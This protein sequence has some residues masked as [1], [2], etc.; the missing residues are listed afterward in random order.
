MSTNTKTETTGQ[1]RLREARERAAALDAAAVDEAA[2][3]RVAQ[4]GEW[5]HS[6][7]AVRALRA[8]G[9]TI[10]RIVKKEEISRA[11]VYRALAD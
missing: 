9:W 1:R 11:S 4:P 5:L 2:S 10:D 7:A 8:Q 3:P 6:V